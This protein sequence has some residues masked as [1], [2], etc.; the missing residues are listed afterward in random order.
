MTKTVDQLFSPTPDE[1]METTKNMPK[2][3]LSLYYFGFG[4][5]IRNEFG[6]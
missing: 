6:L 2:K 1:D 5:F 3:D 4:L